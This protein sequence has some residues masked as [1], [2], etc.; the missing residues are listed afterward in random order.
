LPGIAKDRLRLI[1][2]NPAANKAALLSHLRSEE[3]ASYKF[4]GAD[5]RELLKAPLPSLKPPI[6]G[7]TSKRHQAQQAGKGTGDL[8]TAPK[9]QES[10]AMRPGETFGNAWQQRKRLRQMQS[11]QVTKQT[12]RAERADTTERA[13][14][15]FGLMTLA[16]DTALPQASTLRDQVPSNRNALVL[17]TDNT[18]APVATARLHERRTRRLRPQSS[19]ELD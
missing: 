18:L 9:M 7:S 4:R 11:R 16:R 19:R 14:A 8:Q 1:T 13:Q 12:R 3:H 17:R 10:T 2:P 6:A 15:A 5:L